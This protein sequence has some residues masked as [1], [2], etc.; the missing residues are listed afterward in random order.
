LQRILN[1]VPA[2]FSTS[3]NLA[4][5]E[6]PK[7]IHEVDISILQGVDGIVVDD[8]L[9]QCTQPSTIIDISSGKLIVVRDGAYKITQ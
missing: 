5:E 8:Q 6:V 4:G 9:N 2:M 1:S 3:A 7:N